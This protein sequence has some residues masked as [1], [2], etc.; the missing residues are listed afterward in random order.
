MEIGKVFRFLDTCAEFFLQ[1]ICQCLNAYRHLKI[2]IKALKTSKEGKAQKLGL[3]DA[4]SAVTI[5]PCCLIL[6]ISENFPMRHCTVWP[7][8][9]QEIKNATS[10]SWKFNSY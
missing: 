9:S 4:R 3:T 7:Y 8:T 2:P 5:E 1:N 6:T 10:R